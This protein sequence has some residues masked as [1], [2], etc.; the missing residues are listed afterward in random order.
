M[1]YAHCTTH[2]YGRLDLSSVFRTFD[3]EAT[4]TNYLC[5]FVWTVTI[6]I[7][8]NQSDE[9]LQLRTYRKLAF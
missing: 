4:L 5:D 3:E 6:T 9:S 7:V 8:F 2:M 1:N